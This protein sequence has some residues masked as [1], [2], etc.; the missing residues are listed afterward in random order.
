M[1]SLALLSLS[2]LAAAAIT[3][4][5]ILDQDEV[6]EREAGREYTVKLGCVGCPVRAWTSPEKAEWLHPSPNSS[7]V[8]VSHRMQEAALANH[9]SVAQ[10]RHDRVQ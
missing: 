3:P 6:I 2:A 7:L 4:Q 10:V 8:G 9:K 5:N 1:R